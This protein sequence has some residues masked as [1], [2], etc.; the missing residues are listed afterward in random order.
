MAGNQ[1][2]LDNYLRSQGYDK[3]L[4][5]HFFTAAPGNIPTF[6]LYNAGGTPFPTL[7]GKKNGTM[8]AP[9]SSC[10]GTKN[11]GAVPWLQLIDGGGSQGGVDMVYRLETAG[12]SAPALCQGQK[13]SVEVP[14]VAQY[15]MF[16]PKK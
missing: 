2:L 1:W 3:L 9:K 14:Y 15:W 8:D 12:G 4:G 13:A 16:G 11:E 10:P 5:Q 6:S 7:S